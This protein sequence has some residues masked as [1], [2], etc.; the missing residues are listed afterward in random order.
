MTH[1]N[2]DRNDIIYRKLEFFKSL[3]QEVHINIIAGEDKGLWRNGFI[4]DISKA[5]NC[6]V[7][8]DNI[9][10]ERPYLFEEVDEKIVKRR[11][12]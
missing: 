12:G 8:M 10:G 4:L 3:N 2:N 9:L 11:V 6:F 5:Q 7:F 1:D